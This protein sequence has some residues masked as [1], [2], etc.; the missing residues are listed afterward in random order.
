[1][2]SGAALIEMVGIA[3]MHNAC[4]LWHIG[5]NYP[6]TQG[7]ERS[8]VVISLPTNNVQYKLLEEGNDICM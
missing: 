3:D 5:N 7:K 6:F 2:K 8:E 1:M 4:R